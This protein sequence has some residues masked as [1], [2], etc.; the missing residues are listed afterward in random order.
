VVADK[1]EHGRRWVRYGPADQ[2]VS[3]TRWMSQ[4]VARR[5]TEQER[6]RTERRF[7]GGGSWSGRR[8]ELISSLSLV[9]GALVEGEAPMLAVETSSPDEAH[10]GGRLR[11]LAEE[12]WSGRAKTVVQALDH[13]RAPWPRVSN[14]TPRRPLGPRSWS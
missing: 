9:H 13:L 10:G 3:V 14:S 6:R 8:G 4:W 2:G 5:R 1:K 7:L 11:I 12:V